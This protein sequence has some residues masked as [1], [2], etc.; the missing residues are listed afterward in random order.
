MGATCAKDSKI[1]ERK[2]IVVFES[3]GGTDKGDD[4][5]RKDT[6]PIIQAI[7]K[8][9]WHAECIKFENDKAEQIYHEVAARFSGYIGRVNPGSFPGN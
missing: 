2:A 3:I 8:L 1:K 6:I 9:G 5:Y 4:G 7:K